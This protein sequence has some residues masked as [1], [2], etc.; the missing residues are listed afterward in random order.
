MAFWLARERSGQ[1]S[2]WIQRFDPRFW[3]VNHPRPML[4]AATATAPDA[5]RIDATFM[6]TGDLA[7]VIWDSVDRFDH[8][9]LAYATDRDYTRTALSFR[10]RSSGV[11]PLDHDQ[12]PTL[13]VEGRDAAG[14]ARVWYVRLWNYRSSGTGTD[15]RIV[16]PFSSLFGGFAADD[17]STPV[18]PGAIDRLFVSLVPPGYTAAGAGAPLPAPAEAWVELSE[19]HCDGERAMLAIGDVLVPPH[20]LGCATAYDDQCHLT[21][22]RVLRNVEGLGYR[23]T[24]L[25]YVGM[26]RA[27]RIGAAPG[28][29]TVDG[30]GAALAP[31]A[32]AWHL[33]LLR[34][35]RAAGLSPQLSFSYEVLAAWCPD[36]WQQRGYDGTPARTGWDPP[37]ALLSPASA[38]AMAWLQ[39]LACELAALQRAA[40]CPV[41]IQIGEPWWWI[42]AQRRPCVYDAAARA[43]L[44]GNPPEIADLARPLSAIQRGV[45]DR[46]GGILAESTAGLRDAI[47]AEAAPLGA[48]VAL[49]AFLPSLLDPARPEVRRANLPPAWAAPAFDRLQLEDYDWLT[50]GADGPRRLAYAAVAAQLGYPPQQTDYLAGFA[51]DGA[52]AVPWQR[53]DA[54]ADEAR[55]NWAGDVIVWA[56]PQICRD[57]FVRLP[58][59]LQE[60]AVQPFDD[61]SFPLALGRDAS[62]IP[63]FSTSVMV[64]AS[65]HERRNSLWSDARLRFD[66]G[67]GIRSAEDLGVLIAFFRARRGAA[68]GFRLRDPSDCSSNGMTGTPTAVDQLL[69]LGDGLATGFALIK[70]YGSEDPQVRRITRPVAGS[71]KVSLNGVATHDWILGPG[72]IVIFTAAPPRGARVCAGFLFDVPVRFAE[73][74]LAIAGHAFGAGEVA[75]VPVIELREAA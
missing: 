6:T 64:T 54:G 73:D 70:R 66:L 61:V 11:L 34:E 72:G 47:R 62:V 4:A 48:E 51:P 8:P 50:A 1:D 23:G 27:L 68:R 67:P 36:S 10:W 37:S 21:P 24:L 12:G 49:L 13:T 9:L 58:P 32:R 16:L 3:T 71:L 74:T 5:L 35:A 43:R 40:G 18:H 65:G 29:W 17:R 60:D 53:I 39:R 33:A 19:L 69:G 75:S 46:A 20:G 25:H 30:P 45:L 41:R 38:A 7:G 15:A 42:D 14:A 22:S 28:G 2:D 56:L 57:G 59:T 31:P 63:A 26:N 44:G 52:G 55:H